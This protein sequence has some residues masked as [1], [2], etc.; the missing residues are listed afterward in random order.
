MLLR[1]KEILFP[2]TKAHAGLLEY[3]SERVLESLPKDEIPVRFV[4]TRTDDK[5]YH[6]ELGMLSDSEGFTNLS[7]DTILK[8]KKRNFENTDRF[9]AV[10]LIPTGI[11]AEIGG[12]SGDG[13]PVARLLASACDNLITHPNVV[14]ASDINE[15]PENGLYVEGSVITR[16]LM[17]TV[18]LQKVRANRIMLVIDKHDDKFF[19]EAAVN[20]VSAARAT[21]GLDCPVVVRMEGKVHMMSL[22]STSGRAVGKIEYLERLCDVLENYKSQYDA[23]ALS[24][25]IGV[26]KNFH[27]DYFRDDIDMVNPWGGVEA[28]LTHAISTLYNVPSAHSPMMCSR[29]ILDIDVGIVDPRKSAEAVSVTYLHCIL[30]GLLRSPRIINNSEISGA[31]AGLLGVTDISCLVIPYGCLGL[32]TLAALEQGIP[33]IAVRENKNHMQNKLDELPFA[34][35]KLFIVDNYLEAVGVMNAIKAGIAPESVRRPISHTT[36]VD[37]HQ[38][39]RPLFSKS[40]GEGIQTSLEQKKRLTNN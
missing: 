32:P 17:G 14:N 15:L 3:L 28:M 29:E 38:N 12:H 21:L 13:G 20:A 4:V 40:T 35:G 22:Y 9:N 27:T 24:S 19:H 7:R 11:G 8:F 26:S 33:V 16:L 30:K 39:Q 34:H 18:S 10:L 36:V 5:G 1:E 25:V 31:Q 6:C 23:V 2:N 37:S